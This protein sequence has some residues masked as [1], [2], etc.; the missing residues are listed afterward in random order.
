MRHLF[1][2]VNNCVL[3]HILAHMFTFLHTLLLSLKNS[4]HFLVVLQ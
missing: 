3:I 4:Y 1:H 2:S